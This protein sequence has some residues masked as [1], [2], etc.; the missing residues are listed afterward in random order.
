MGKLSGAGLALISIGA[1]RFP[2]ALMRSLRLSNVSFTVV[3]EITVFLANDALNT[4]V[5][6]A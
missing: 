6:W 2:S 5:D 4:W 3:D 1:S